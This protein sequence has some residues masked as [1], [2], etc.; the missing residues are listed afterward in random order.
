MFYP[1]LKKT[2]EKYRICDRFSGMSRTARVPEGS[3]YDCM[4]LSSHRLPL[5]GVREKRG[6][7]RDSHGE[8]V[9]YFDS[10][11]VTAVRM[12][13]SKL[14]VCT[15]RSVYI[16]GQRL[17]AELSPLTGKRTVVPFGR[18]LYI[19]P[20]A[21]F[22]KERE[23]GYS[24]VECNK[25]FTL[26]DN[27]TVGWCF[28]DST[29]LTPSYFGNFPD[30]AVI[31]DY[32]I[33]AEGG[34]MTLYEYTGDKWIS[35]APMFIRIGCRDL[36]DGIAP[37]MSLTVTTEEKYFPDGTYTVRN[38]DPSAVVL[39]G[40]VK[41][42][43]RLGSITLES[44]VPR[45]DFAA[46]HNNRIWGCRFGENDKGEFVNELY[47]SALGDPTAWSR[48]Q[49]IST[50]SYAVSL[51]VHGEFTGA[52]SLGGEL[53]FFKE[54]TIIRVTGDTPS[55]FSVST[56]P[57]RGV[58]SGASDS[59]TSL[60][61]RVLYKNG[62]GITVYD[63]AFPVS[64]SAALGNE[65]FSHCTGAG[66]QG[67]YYCAMTDSSGQRRIYVFDTASSQ[68]FSEDD[69]RNTVFAFSWGRAVYFLGL[70]DAENYGYT[71]T[72]AAYGTV[73]GSELRFSS[74]AR[75]RFYEEDEVCW[76][77]E[78]GDSENTAY[79][80]KRS[81]RSIK[82]KVSLKEDSEFSLLVKTD[83][84]SEF[85]RVLFLEGATDGVYSAHV[86]TLPCHSLRLRFEGKG[87][88]TVHSYSAAQ[89]ISS[90]VRA[91]E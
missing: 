66:A 29:E 20:D 91:V 41:S 75:C 48:F 52:V 57:A 67:R 8:S 34:A 6:I 37:G 54:N 49:G 78:T 32:C 35:I 43:G 10:T 82:L 62:A 61:E 63:G 73:S 23:D 76:F 51:G 24:V 7:L 60:N 25:S 74:S 86:N 46:E 56:F 38:V 79:P 14:C 64:I 2:Q 85:R 89:R 88:V 70:A 83:R 30:R 13:N 71:L 3:F 90:E 4:N 17:D 39:E 36:P 40:I 1:V 58:E 15:E 18:D 27:V 69:A 42:E 44:R 33:I 19:C 65:V 50:D 28:E 68:W 55:E 87:D 84:D 72:A 81:V 11:P 9:F 31:G 47:A 5:A 21:L 12:I 77:A 80:C 22:I 59:I 16:D 45:M 53:L 26:S